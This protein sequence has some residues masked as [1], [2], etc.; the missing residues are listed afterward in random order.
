MRLNGREKR[1]TIRGSYYYMV[2]EKRGSPGSSHY[3]A[4]PLGPDQVQD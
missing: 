4:I 3:G 2:D 1:F